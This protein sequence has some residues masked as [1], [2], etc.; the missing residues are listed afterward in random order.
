VRIQHK[1]AWSVCAK[2]GRSAPCRLK[3]QYNAA[4]RM[5]NSYL[6][7]ARYH[8]STLCNIWLKSPIS[9]SALSCTWVSTVPNAYWL[10]STCRQYLALGSGRARTGA[11]LSAVLRV[12]KECWQSLSQANGVRLILGSPRHRP[13]SSFPMGG[14]PMAYNGIPM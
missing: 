11:L 1:V 7:Y 5:P 3:F 13:I 6:S 10:S 14:V 8:V 9:F 2:S 4:S 12:S